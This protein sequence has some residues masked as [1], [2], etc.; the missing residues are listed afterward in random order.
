MA[1]L[2]D[3][4]PQRLTSLEPARARCDRNLAPREWS[5]RDER[6]GRLSREGSGRAERE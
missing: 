5:D 3:A 6:H 1:E 2:L 4:L